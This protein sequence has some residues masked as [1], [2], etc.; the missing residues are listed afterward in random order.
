MTT[1]RIDLYKRGHF[2][3]EGKQG[4]DE[5]AIKKG[6]GTRG[7]A[8][9]D[10]AMVRAKKQGENYI[11]AL[12]SSEGRPPFLIVVD[13]GHSI[14]IYSEFTCTGGIYVPFPD[15]RTHRIFLKD[16]A[17]DDVRE[18][19]RQIWTEPQALD[20]ALRAARVTRD[21]ADQLAKLAKSLEV[22]GNSPAAVGGFLM[23]C[24]FTMFAEDV[25]L[26]PKKS[27][28]DLLKSIR[29]E[30]AQFVPLVKSVWE[31][32]NDGG[33][34]VALR[35]SLLRFNGGL[36]EERNPLPVTTEQIDLLIAAAKADWRDVEPAIFGTLL[37][38]ALDP[39][40]RHKLGAHYTPRDYVERLVMPTVIEPLRE[41]WEDVQAAA[42]I[43]LA[44]DKP[45][46][47]V[48][49]V[50]NFLDQLCTT[51]VL[52]PACGSGNFLYV[53]MEH[54]KRL[55]SLEVSHG[56]SEKMTH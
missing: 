4:A 35:H 22:S 26:L 2:V 52:D 32:M 17:K 39:R 10:K 46:D 3:M 51:K 53:T 28:E 29:D 56:G 8:G 36:F 18:T 1:G 42:A 55:E 5:G 49:V 16:L 15:P 43:H 33:F 31:S 34:C 21:I 14:E 48:R 9:W 47:A 19:L 30:P 25:N 54:M 7:S 23:R 27:F 50:A 38:H 6:H 41:Q 44:T 24:I 20:P 45:K 37:E 40:E 12:P 11:H 13:V